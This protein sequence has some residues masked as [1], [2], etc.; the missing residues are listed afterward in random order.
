MVVWII[1]GFV[2]LISGMIGYM[3]HHPRTAQAPATEVVATTSPSTA[4]ATPVTTDSTGVF[5]LALGETGESHG[6]SVTPVSVSDSRCPVG[7]QCVW[8]GEVTVHVKLSGESRRVVDLRLLESTTTPNGKIT[9]LKVAPE[10]RSQTTKDA[11]Y[12]FTFLV[13]NL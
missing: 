6:W 13:E 9:F 11:E 4:S 10:K 3:T 12:R 1:G 5:T 7:V 8:A 2:V